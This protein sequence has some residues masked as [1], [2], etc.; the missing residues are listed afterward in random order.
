MKAVRELWCIVLIDC[1][2]SVCSVVPILCL[3]AMWYLLVNYCVRWMRFR[4]Q[5]ESAQKKYKNHSTLSKLAEVARILEEVTL[6]V[7][8]TQCN[9]RACLDA[10]HFASILTGGGSDQEETERRLAGVV[11]YTQV[12]FIRSS[13]CTCT[14]F[15]WRVF[16][17]HSHNCRKVVSDQKKWN[18]QK[19]SKRKSSDGFERALEVLQI[20]KENE[21]WSHYFK[22]EQQPDSKV[23][24]HAKFSQHSDSKKQDCSKH[25]DSKEFSQHS[26]SEKQDCS[27]HADSK[28]FSQHSESEKQDCSK[29]ADSKEFSR[30]SDSE[31]QDCS[32]HPESK[33]FSQ[34]PDSKKKECSKHPDSKEFSQHPDSKTK[35][36]SNH[37]DSEN[38]LKSL[39][40]H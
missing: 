11:R 2:A 34:H 24:D 30:H 28:E 19:L 25:A 33:E 23:L 18:N 4:N 31:K 10:V 40:I 35:E 38:V 37:P 32:K 29:H 7:W 27:K 14:V 20:L 22:D 5:Q 3:P 8:L 13:L 16:Q 6:W 12:N 21:P 26:E 1:I 36:C 9:V 15:F 17:T 39:D